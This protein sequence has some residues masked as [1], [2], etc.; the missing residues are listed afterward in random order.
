MISL[1]CLFCSLVHSV[2]VARQAVLLAQLVT[3]VTARVQHSARLAFTAPTV[4]KTAK[5]A[6]VD[7]SV[8]LQMHLTALPPLC[9]VQVAAGATGPP[10]SHVLTDISA[11]LHVRPRSRRA[12]V[13]V[14]PV[15]TAAHRSAPMLNPLH[16]Q[17][18]TIAHQAQSTPPR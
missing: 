3:L 17:Q 15:R 1:F 5:P 14:Q 2:R 12:A 8:W 13:S 4:H 7:F 11:T 16:V 6:A 9:R 18:A 10:F